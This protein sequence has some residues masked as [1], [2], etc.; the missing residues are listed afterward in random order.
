MADKNANDNII[1]TP[2][3]RISFP[4][5]NKPRAVNDGDTPK[6]SLSLLFDKE[7][8]ES[9]QFKRMRREVEKAIEEKWGDNPPRKLKTPFLTIDDMDKI[10]D[11][12]DED[13]VFIRVSSTIRPGLVDQHKN[14]VDPDDARD[15]F[16][17]GHYARAAVHVYAWQHPQGG[18]GVSFGLDHVQYARKG[19]PFGNKTDPD[20]V[21]DALEDEDEDQDEPF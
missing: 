13:T 6:F 18:K 14:A 8:Q 4:N 16:V 20:D 15:V 1:T 3:G 7:A 9:K 5:L 10:P 11:G 2:V 12:Y 19:E 17:P 21:F